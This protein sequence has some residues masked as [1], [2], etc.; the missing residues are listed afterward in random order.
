MK[1]NLAL[2][3]FAGLSFT[4]TM[5]Q[6]ASGRTT[7]ETSGAT[8]SGARADVPL[9]SR[10]VLFGNPER[11]GAQLS[12]DGKQIAF[13]APLNGVMNVF[14]A[15]VGDITK[16]RAITSEKSRAIRQ[17]SWAYNNTHILYLQD[18]GGDENWRLY[19]VETATGAAKDLTPFD[20]IPG[21]D[22]KPIMLPSG[23]P[24]RPTAQ[25]VEASD[26]TPDELVVGLN[27]RNPQYHDLYRCNIK[28]GQ[29]TKI[30]ENNEWAGVVVDDSYTPR[31]AMRFTPDGGIEY[32]K[33]GEGGKTEPFEKVGQE[34]TMTTAFSG[35]DK[36]GR[37]LYYTDSRG[38]NT[39]AFFARDMETGQSTM[40]AE[41]PRCDA[42]GVLSDPK[43]G[44]VQAV[45]FNYMRNEWT[46]LD[47]TLEPDFAYLRTVRSGEIVVGS[48]A[49]DDS[50]WIVGYTMDDGPV[51]VYLYERR[52]D[53]KPEAA[54]FLYTNRPEL[55]K[56]PLSKMHPV[57]IK[58]R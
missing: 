23:K 8:I 12:H 34:D 19:S 5:A 25:I 6:S 39:G 1:M 57:E 41:D 37:T 22:G 48:R 58:S 51:Y 42:G 28:T 24:L 33:F 32:M 36:S 30:Y 21:P 35:F 44:K 14:V 11:G 27:N 10:K 2:A 38:R 55:E 52:N 53:G 54:T 56:Q 3:L 18:D 20:S 16:A 45:S 43:T 26:K 4:F 9:I 40:L 17:Y 50:R 47:K 7:D 13:L 15:P 49:L 31:L 29:L 46:V